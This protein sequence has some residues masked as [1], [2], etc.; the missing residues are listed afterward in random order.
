MKYIEKF[1]INQ[2][3]V[4]NKAE[5]SK[6]RGGGTCICLNSE[7]HIVITGAAQSADEC[8]NMCSAYGTTGSYFPEGTET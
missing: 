2:E 7:G 8:Q 4:L 5:L 6:L 3:K 1:E